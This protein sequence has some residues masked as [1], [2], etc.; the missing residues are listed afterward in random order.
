PHLVI[1]TAFKALAVLGPKLWERY[2]TGD[3]LLFTDEDFRAPAS[4]KLMMELWQSNNPGLQA[5][6]GHLACACGK[7]IPQTPWLD[8][9]APDGI[10]VPLSLEQIQA[11]AVAL[12]TASVSIAPVAA[13]DYGVEAV[14]AAPAVAAPPPVNPLA[15]LDLQPVPQ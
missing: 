9:I 8:Q 12:G 11:S 2:D 13:G 10:V 5:L 1:A 7:P 14:P 4:S 3:N 6:V 15:D